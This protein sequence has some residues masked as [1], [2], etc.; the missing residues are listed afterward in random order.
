MGIAVTTTSL[1]ERKSDQTRR[2]GMVSAVILGAIAV[3]VIGL[4]VAGAVIVARFF[5][6]P[7]ATFEVV[8]EFRIPV[9]R[10][11]TR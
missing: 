2:R 9:K 11:S 8:R 6:E 10:V 1:D 4:I 7:K 5:A 3:H